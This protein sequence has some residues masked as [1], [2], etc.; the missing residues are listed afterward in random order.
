[1]LDYAEVA[2]ADSLERLEEI[3]PERRAV[4]LLAARVGSTRLIDNALLTE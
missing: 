4:A 2:D 3:Q 1:M